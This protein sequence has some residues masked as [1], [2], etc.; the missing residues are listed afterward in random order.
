MDTNSNMVRPILQVVHTLHT[1]FRAKNAR[2][3][4]APPAGYVIFPGGLDWYC[5]PGKSVL[6]WV[7]KDA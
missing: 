1:R 3:L 5:I 2:N 4:G 6:T 7:Q